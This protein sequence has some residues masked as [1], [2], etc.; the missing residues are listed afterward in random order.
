MQTAFD[1][2]SELSLFIGG[3]DKLE[4]TPLN[5]ELRLQQRD[6]ILAEQMELRE[7]WKNE[8]G[9]LPDVFKH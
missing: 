4:T 1:W 5:N 3:D 2:R 7:R 9:Q 8:R 6:N